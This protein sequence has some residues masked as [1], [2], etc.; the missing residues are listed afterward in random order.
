MSGEIVA[1]LG[2]V[3]VTSLISSVHETFPPVGGAWV[4]LSVMV[5]IIPFPVLPASVP[6]SVA[7]KLTEPSVWLI[8]PGSSMEMSFGL[9][10]VS[11][12]PVGIDALVA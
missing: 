1:L 5:E 4:M 12:W 11:Q 9:T 2:S 10:G 3:R 8:V 6:L 7:A